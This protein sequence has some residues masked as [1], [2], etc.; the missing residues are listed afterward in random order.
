MS[1]GYSRYPNTQYPDLLRPFATIAPM[2]FNPCPEAPTILM[3]MRGMALG[4]TY[5]RRNIHQLFPP[6]SYCL[7]LTI[8]LVDDLECWKNQAT[9]MR[10]NV[11][12]QMI[13]GPSRVEISIVPEPDGCARLRCQI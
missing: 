2:E 1:E 8:G 3:D 12:L 6:N 10:F 9:M 11:V 5:L 7:L 4:P 13:R